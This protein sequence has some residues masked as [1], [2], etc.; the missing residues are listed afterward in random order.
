MCLG[1]TYF[2]YAGFDGDIQSWWFLAGDGIIDVPD[3]DDC[4][5]DADSCAIPPAPVDACMVLWSD[6]YLEGVSTKICGDQPFT[7]ID[8]EVKSIYVDSGVTGY[9]YNLPCFNG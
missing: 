7:D 8:Y 6:C 1:R 5:F 2:N 9:L 3:Y 4:E